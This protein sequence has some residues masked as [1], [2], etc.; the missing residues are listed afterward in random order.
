MQNP[1]QKEQAFSFRNCLASLATNKHNN[2]IEP[3]IFIFWLIPYALTTSYSVVEGDSGEFLG[4]AAVQGVPHDPGFPLYS[5]ITR[6]VY[7]LPFGHTA[8]AINIVS[9]IFASLALVIT[10]RLVTLITNDINAAIFSV[11]TLGTYEYFWFYAVVTQIHTLQV[12]LLVLFSYFLVLFAKTNA[13]KYLYFCAFIMGLGIAHSYTIIFVIPS[14]LILMY[15]LK[16]N[17]LFI[18]FLKALLFSLIG[19]FLYIY[20]IWASSSMPLINWG[21]IHDFN[22]F[23]FIFFRGDYGLFSLGPQSLS[24]PFVY[25]SFIYYFESLFITSWYI[26]PFAFLS[27]WLLYKKNFI[28]ILLF[29]IFILIGPFFYLLLN[30]PIIAVSYKANVEQYL[31]YSFLYISI[32]AGLGL[33]LLIT[34]YKKIQ[35]QR[36]IIL[37][38]SLLFFL[39]PFLNTF[40]DMKLET[41]GF[42]STTM[43]FMLS[44]IPK[45]GV[46]LTTGDDFYFPS[47]YWQYFKNYRRDITVI[48]FTLSASWYI[49][50]L[51]RQHPELK[52]LTTPQKF[53]SYLCN[54]RAD[55]G[56]LFVYPWDAGFEVLFAHKCTIIPY[57]LV[58]KVVPLKEVP[59]A[60]RLKIFNDSVWDDY[61]QKVTLNNYKK[62]SSR[63]REFLLSLADQ[64]SFTGFYYE[65]IGENDW[66]VDEYK[67]SSEISPDE[68]SSIISESTIFYKR[69][70]I[71]TAISLL[72]EGINRDSSTAILYK[73]R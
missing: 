53:Y 46:I 17:I 42:V 24:I 68:V 39:I 9:A 6:L 10:Y 69:G 23:L 50:N 2:W 14:L 4:S 22:S 8:W 73:G 38:I 45:N 57:G 21:R 41:D 35:S 33:N 52:F 60:E 7:L 59:N 11:L 16:K 1:E 20:T 48:N 70:D 58:D 51:H 72:E 56:E 12:L 37:I 71:D 3:L 55:K 30:Q 44:E 34:R 66:A 15:S 28:Y 67:R 36:L 29:I 65:K 27:L 63:T 18:N 47:L 64:L 26:L 49:Q 25:S 31:S 5:L 13:I 40:D 61:S 54:D 43:K 19:L 32:F 62:T